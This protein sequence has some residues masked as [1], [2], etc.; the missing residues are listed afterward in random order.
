L[1]VNAYWE[2][3]CFSLPDIPD[4]RGPWCR[5]IDTFQ[6]PPSDFLE[7]EAETKQYTTYTVQSRS[8]VLLSAGPLHP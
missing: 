1:M 7:E 3:L 5:L 2:P 4:G 8:I 6:S